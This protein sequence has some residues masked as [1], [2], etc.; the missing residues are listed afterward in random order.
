MDKVAIGTI[1][2][3]GFRQNWTCLAVK[4]AS[5]DSPSGK[6]AT[7]KLS[8]R[9]LNGQGV[10]LQLGLG[11]GLG[12]GNGIFPF[13]FF[14]LCVEVWEKNFVVARCIYMTYWRYVNNPI[15]AIMSWWCNLGNGDMEK[16]CPQCEASVPV[17]QK[18]VTV[19]TLWSCLSIRQTKSRV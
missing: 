8:L 3:Q 10:V 5:R 13:F 14:F 15:I 18:T 19:W 17:R 12:P 2:V 9:G 11:L 7:Y 6:M 4:I 16:V 1:G